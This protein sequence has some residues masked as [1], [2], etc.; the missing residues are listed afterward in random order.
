MDNEEIGKA[1]ITNVT[2]IPAGSD[3]KKTQD[4]KDMVKETAETISEVM[5]DFSDE[6]IQE[7]QEVETEMNQKLEEGK[8]KVKEFLNYIKTPEFKEKINSEAKKCKVPPKVYAESFFEKALGSIS[9]VLNIAVSTVGGAVHSLIDLLHVV[10]ISGVDIVQK[11][12]TS[13]VNIVTLN[14]TNVAY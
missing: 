6:V 7:T 2:A 5:S 11:V 1:T 13:L 10:L 3:E 12:A 4:I 14:K 9:D 8:E